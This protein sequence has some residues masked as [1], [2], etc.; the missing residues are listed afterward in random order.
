[1]AA[2]VAATATTS[3]RPVASE[4]FA[5]SHSFLASSAGFLF[6]IERAVACSWKHVDDELHHLASPEIAFALRRLW[7]AVVV[8]VILHRPGPFVLA[9]GVS[10]VG[11]RRI[12]L[13]Q[14][15]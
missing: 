14:R 7:L 10:A 12:A 9:L 8:C 1:M 4:S 5:Q 2:V 15:P 11:L 13:D 6:M 3:Q